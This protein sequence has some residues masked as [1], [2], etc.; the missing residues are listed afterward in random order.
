MLHTRRGSESG[1]WVWT[2]DGY[3]TSY[4]VFVV[5]RLHGDDIDNDIA[6]SRD[7]DQAMKRRGNLPRVLRK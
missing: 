1:I 5:G 7:R 3:Q 4:L 2:I 6:A